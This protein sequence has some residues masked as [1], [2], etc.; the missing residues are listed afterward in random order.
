MPF[1]RVM[2]ITAYRMTFRH[3]CRYQYFI[4]DESLQ[5]AML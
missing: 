3:A 1:F 5:D 4:G 2:F